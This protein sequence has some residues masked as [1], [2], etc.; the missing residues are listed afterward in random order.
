M[1]EGLYILVINALYLEDNRASAIITTRYH[2]VIVAHPALHYR[3]TLQ[4][5]VDIPGYGIPSL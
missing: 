1:K 2:G 4:T 5:C 3:T